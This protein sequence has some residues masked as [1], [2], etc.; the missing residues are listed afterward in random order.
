M[1]QGVAGPC[2][3]ISYHLDGPKFDLGEVEKAIVQ[4]VARKCETI[5]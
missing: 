4:Y 3:L 1:F 5:L 2:E